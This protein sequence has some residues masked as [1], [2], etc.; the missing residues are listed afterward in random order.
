MTCPQVPG[1]SLTNIALLL[2]D[3]GWSAVCWQLL[4]Q[5]W[6]MRAQVLGSVHSLHL[7][8][9]GHYFFFRKISPELIAANPP[10]LLLKKTGPELTSM[11]IFLYFICGTPTTAW[12]A[13]WCHVR[14]RDPNRQT[15]GHPPRSRTCALNHCATGPAPWPLF[16]GS[17]AEQ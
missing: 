3:A 10:L 8:H 1:C 4:N 6:L 11:P 13:K 7:C 9:H 15:P 16:N 12:R 2:R 5:P 14:T 17:F